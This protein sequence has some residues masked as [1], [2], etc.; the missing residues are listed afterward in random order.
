MR[1]LLLSL[2]AVLVAG[3]CSRPGE[4][5]VF[6]AASLSPVLSSFG[7]AY[8]RRHP[9]WRLRLEP[10]GSLVAA[11]KVSE[12]GGR[13]DLVMTADD[14]VLDSMLLPEHAAWVITFATNEIVL[15]HRDHSRHTAEITADNWPAI[16]LGDDVR[17]AR[18]NP[19]TA[20]LGYN[21]L[22]VWQLTAL[23]GKGAAPDL[24]A[25]LRARV[26]PENLVPDEGELVSLLGARAIDYA[27]VYRS[28]ALTHHLK[29]VRLPPEVNL[30]N[31]GRDPAYG[32][33]RAQVQLDGAGRT[34]S[35]SAVRYGLT[36]PT[37]AP[38]PEAAL[39]LLDE[40]LS[41]EG[42]KLF[43]RFGFS[44]LRPARWRGRGL[45]ASLR[46]HAVVEDTGGAMT[47]P[48]TMEGAP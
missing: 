47:Q 13:P 15:A 9:G 26:P 11:R 18:A 5:V 38:H 20:P 22:F 33:A 7:E 21:T 45:P 6:H 41:D 2:C 17:L 8:S 37:Q 48:S 25:R 39:L 44:P 34:L 28:T 1:L 42:Q 31:P 29:F 3:A 32:R 27:F 36:V 35:G 43:E 16:L 12:L 19:D 46:S 40:L 10:S 24:E 23:L 30:G 14:Q 4:V